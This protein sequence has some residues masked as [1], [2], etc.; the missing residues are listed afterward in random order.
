M[1][2]LLGIVGAII[3]TLT[4]GI[5]LVAC[6][7]EI[8]KIDSSRTQLYVGTYDGAYG[9]AWLY[10]AKEKF[11]EKY[12]DVHF[13]EGKTGVQV[14]IEP[15]G[16]Y[17][18]T[19][20]RDTI[21]NNKNDVF[22][23]EDVNYYDFVGL[24]KIANITD[25]VTT[26]LT[27]FGE[28]KT[29]ESKLDP[30]VKNFLKRKSDNQ[31]FALPFYQAYGGII[32]DMDLFADNYFYLSDKST[33]EKPAFVS[34]SYQTKSYGLDGE[35]G[36][37]DDGLPVTYD[38]F[39]ALCDRIA[40]AGMTPLIWSGAYPNYLTYLLQS[41][42]ADYE[43]RD[44]IMRNFTFEGETT[45]LKM[46]N[47]RVIQ[48]ADGSYQTETLKVTPETG[49]DLARQPGRYY[50]LKFLEKIMTAEGWRSQSCTNT[51]ADQNTTH[52]EYLRSAYS[53]SSSPIAM[54]I[55][56]TWWEGEAEKG[57]QFDAVAA[58]NPGKDRMG[59]NLGFMP[60]P[61]ATRDKVV[62]KSTYIALNKTAAMINAK[63]TGVSLDLAKK[64]L[65]YCYTDAALNDFSAITS[66]SFFVNYEVTEETK[67]E[68][69]PYGRQ[70]LQIRETSDIIYP[71]SQSEMFMNNQVAL[72]PNSLWW[73]N[74]DGM[75]YK[76]P[77]SYM[78]EHTGNL[79]DVYFKGIIDYYNLNWA[80]Y[81]GNLH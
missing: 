65:M 40:S 58:N 76:I 7:G 55:E 75:T 61:K 70:L 28:N 8:E 24:G 49:N 38:E 30:T 80:G 51:F 34:K 4:A 19:S 25:V 6:G 68:M 54:M 69:S 77:A 64:F 59:R 67:K 22:F 20:L 42:W 78:K 73:A 9:T 36:T 1:K 27:E 10:R 11:E 81:I 13:E 26:P 31:Y 5:S 71:A 44:S 3:L 17:I 48:N 39:F 74:I 23:I 2:K 57:G 33:D 35:P 21:Q 47:G 16:S 46:E 79:A 14:L 63:S 66:S 32:Y 53:S 37:F 29:I 12:K 72:D 52:L 18:G 45:I 43:G 41:L 15:N 62:E 60:L 50:A 56:A